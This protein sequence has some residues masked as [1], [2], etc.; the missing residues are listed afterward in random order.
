MLEEAEECQQ[1]T[2]D[3]GGQRGECENEYRDEAAGDLHDDLSKYERARDNDALQRVM[4]LMEPLIW[5]SF[6]TIE[7]GAFPKST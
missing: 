6:A 2:D 5:R 4:H 3:R 7:F 1:I